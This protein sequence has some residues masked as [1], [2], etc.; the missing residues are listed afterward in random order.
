MN[1]VGKL[2]LNR[3]CSRVRNTVLALLAIAGL[4]VGCSKNSGDG[5]TSKEVAPPAVRAG[6]PNV[7][8]KVGPYMG[9]G[10]KKVAD[11][12]RNGEAFAAGSAQ[13]R[14]LKNILSKS[15]QRSEVLD[16]H[17]DHQSDSQGSA[18]PQGQNTQADQ[19]NLILAFPIK[20]LG[21]QFLFGGVATK[22]SNKTDENLGQLKLLELSPLHVRPILTGVDT[23]TPQLTLMGCIEGCSERSVAE[24][25]LNIPVVGVDTAN[26]YLLVN[27]SAIGQE[28][29]LISIF[30]PEGQ[31]TELKPRASY[32]SMLDY[33]AATLVFDV[34]G[35]M[36]PVDADPA[37]P[38]APVTKFTFRWFLKPSSGFD[39]AFEVRDPVSTVGFF[40]TERS[41]KTRITR[42]NV[43][44]NVEDTVHYFIKNVPDAYKGPFK[45]ALDQWNEKMRPVFGRDFIS[46][47]FVDV[48]D[49]RHEY[50]Q[51]GDIRYSVIE[52]DIDNK[53]PY[54]GFGPSIAHQFSGEIFSA[55]VLIQGPTILNL[56]RDWFKVVGQ[57]EALRAQGLTQAADALI[58]KFRRESEAKS[59][60]GKAKVRMG[61]HNLKIGSLL[62]PLQD[63]L[64]QRNDFDQLPENEN[65]DSYMKGYFTEMVE[66]EVGHNLGLRHNFHGNLGDD[67]SN[68]VG[69]TSRSVMEY[70][71][72]RY[73]YNDRI[74]A[75]DVMAMS[76]GY[77]GV[78]P[79]HGDWFC[80]D[81]NVSTP[82]NMSVASAEC[83]RDDAT[84][85]PFSYFDNRMAQAVNYLIN[86][87]SPQAP[88]WQVGDMPREI[89]QSVLGLALYAGG[90]DN[91]GA[92][93]NFSREGRPTTPD[94][95]REFVL[96]TIKSHLCDPSLESEINAKES[97]EGKL[98][99]R[100]NVNM[101]RT[102]V[103]QALSSYG[104]FTRQQV[105][106]P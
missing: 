88:V 36:I 76:Y 71:P 5:T 62:P 66:H 26:S 17:S 95:I 46:Y 60:V 23:P 48:G 86:R 93:T 98:L 33:S 4:T 99:T 45:D 94:E 96:T 6:D 18:L 51:A 80:T 47:E 92:W 97:D 21:E 102:S 83:S 85:D 90:A 27:L 91:S 2:N 74:S 101:L 39:P 53:A 34:D 25:Q 55:N 29:N 44:G 78:T 38:T 40:T 52:W 73:R 89:G 13:F 104:I 49:P 15:L 28:L 30:D 79:D 72:R 43:T 16:D 65:F 100:A 22:V 35:D 75:Y 63:A 14:K 84:S 103:A 57:A 32:T 70:L 56:Y 67:N 59:K 41:A 61:R 24:A 37:D 1:Q 69:T 8:V 20:L 50:I 31:E 81:E 9:V 12:I 64:I 3:S 68:L 54:G 87:G 58:L 106:C 77:S 105:A 42:W 19:T 82:N 11:Q 7:Q 10:A